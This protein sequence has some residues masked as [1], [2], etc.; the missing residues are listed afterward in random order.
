M[1]D[2]LYVRLMEKTGRMQMPGDSI[3]PHG[4]HSKRAEF[5]G[6]RVPSESRMPPPNQCSLCG[7]VEEIHKRVL[8]IEEESGDTIN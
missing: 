5:A 1:A 8:D 4:S 6:D 2:V 7:A 3:V